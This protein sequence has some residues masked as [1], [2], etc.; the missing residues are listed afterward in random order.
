M[1]H[2]TPQM[3]YPFLNHEKTKSLKVI[4]ESKIL[5]IFVSDSESRGN[6]NADH[7]SKDSDSTFDY[8]LLNNRKGDPTDKVICSRLRNSISRAINTSRYARH[9][10]ECN[11]F[12][13][14]F[15]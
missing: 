1:S 15:L 2:A 7:V 5:N 6:P 4:L 10:S 9:V 3:T 13:S 14:I 11:A 12:L 8:R